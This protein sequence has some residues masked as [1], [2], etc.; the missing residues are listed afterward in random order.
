M[1]DQFKEMWGSWRKMQEGMM[2]LWKDTIQPP[3]PE[4][5]S[6]GS[7]GSTQGLWEQ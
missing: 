3:Q 2:D 7:N 6:S 1:S 4:K 5:K